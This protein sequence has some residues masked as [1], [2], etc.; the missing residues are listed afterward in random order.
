M[1]K[2]MFAAV[3]TAGS[4]AAWRKVTQSRAESALWAEATDTIGPEPR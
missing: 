1:K 2:L 4:F 3:A